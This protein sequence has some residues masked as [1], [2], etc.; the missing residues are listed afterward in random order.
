VSKNNSND[1]EKIVID[2]AILRINAGKRADATGNNNTGITKLNEG[3]GFG[4][5][6]EHFTKNKKKFPSSEGQKNT[7]NEK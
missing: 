6:H 7:N 2:T 3:S 4:I 1:D 5:S